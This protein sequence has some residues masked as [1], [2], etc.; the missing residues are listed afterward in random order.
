MASSAKAQDTAPS[1]SALDRDDSLTELENSFKS[2]MAAGQIPDNIA[3]G[4]KVPAPLSMNLL[5]RDDSLMELENSF[6]SQVAAGEIPATI[7]EEVEV[8]RSPV[9][10]PASPVGFAPV[11]VS[12]APVM[13]R[14]SIAVSVPSLAPV[15]GAEPQ[16]RERET[17]RLLLLLLLL[18]VVFLL[19]FNTS[20]QYLR[21]AVRGTKLPQASPYIEKTHYTSLLW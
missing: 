1:A 15:P 2:Q 17:E 12:E 3:Q 8:P 14:R 7:A 11:T 9:G 21:L 5:N 6:K 4:G 16:R 10:V 19:L 13:R 18:L 20:A